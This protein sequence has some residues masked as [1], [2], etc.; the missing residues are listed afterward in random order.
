MLPRKRL[1]KKIVHS[2]IKDR[3]QK[4]KPVLQL[5]QLVRTADIKETFSR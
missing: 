4:R 1:N 3:R 5:G 2:N